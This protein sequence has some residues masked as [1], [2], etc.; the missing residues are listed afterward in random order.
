MR[1]LQQAA[2][3]VVGAFSLPSFSRHKEGLGYSSP[4]RPVW[5]P[6]ATGPAGM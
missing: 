6:S 1:F 2:V 3:V 4:L 5:E